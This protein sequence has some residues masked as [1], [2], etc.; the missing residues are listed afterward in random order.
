MNRKMYRMFGILMVLSLI[1]AACGGGAAPA[2]PAPEAQPAAQSEA[3]ADQS[4]A[5]APSDAPTAEA[6]VC[7]CARRWQ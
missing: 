7:Q 4:S 1:L 2:T 3:P 6:P 5:P